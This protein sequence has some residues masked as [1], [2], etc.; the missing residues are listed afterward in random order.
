LTS[1]L[2]PRLLGDWVGRQQWLGLLLGVLGVALVLLPGWLAGG[3]V[4][5]LPAAGVAACLIALL[6]TTGGTLYQ[7]RHGEDVPL[8]SGTA[9]QYGACTVAFVVLAPPT[10]D[11]RIRWSPELILGMAWLVIALSVGAILL[12]LTLLRRGSATS[13]SSL[14]FLVPPATA[15]EAYLVFGERLG[16]LQLLGMLLAGCGV[17]L[18]MLA[19]PVDPLPASG[20]VE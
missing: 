18:V 4:G 13:V 9:V 11:L 16:V 20:L 1:A 8:L 14:F 5:P 10:E 2:V 19:R 15:L 7:K 6:A 12:L 3:Q 17:A